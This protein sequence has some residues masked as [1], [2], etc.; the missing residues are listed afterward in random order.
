MA[1]ARVPALGCTP[2]PAKETTVVRILGRLYQPVV[3]LVLVALGLAV[4]LSGM[5]S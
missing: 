3:G 1:R 2:A 5:R 4:V